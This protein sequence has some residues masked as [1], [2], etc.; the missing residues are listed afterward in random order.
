[1][2]VCVRAMCVRCVCG[3]CVMCEVCFL[4]PVCYNYTQKWQFLGCHFKNKKSGTSPHKAM[5]M[6]AILLLSQNEIT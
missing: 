4:L 5:A 1:M 3:V 2:N 6:K